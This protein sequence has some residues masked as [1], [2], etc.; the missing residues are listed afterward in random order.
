MLQLIPQ[1]YKGLWGVLWTIIQQ[2][3]GQLRKEMDKFLDIQT[4]QDGIMKK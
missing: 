3:I 2:Q 1:K 4:D